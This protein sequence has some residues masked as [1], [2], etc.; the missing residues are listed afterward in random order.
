LLRTSNAK[1]RLVTSLFRH[2]AGTVSVTCPRCS[3]RRDPK[4]APQD[5]AQVAEPIN[6]IIE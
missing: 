1:L 5:Y 3:R 2:A 4:S 6:A